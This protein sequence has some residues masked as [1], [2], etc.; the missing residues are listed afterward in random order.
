MLV[1]V[2]G[3]T[4]TN[5]SSACAAL[6]RLLY[7]FLLL[8]LIFAERNAITLYCRFLYV[9]ENDMLLVLVN[10]AMSTEHNIDMSRNVPNNVPFSPTDFFANRENDEFRQTRGN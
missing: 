2:V 9:Y 5:S 10:K 3:T 8:Y 1:L 4:N 6:Y 7:C